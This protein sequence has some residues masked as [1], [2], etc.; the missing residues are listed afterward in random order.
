TS[1]GG[2]VPTSNTVTYLYDKSAPTVAATVTAISA[3]TGTA[4]DYIT[5][6]ASQTVRGTFTGT[7]GSCETIQA[8]ANGSTWVPA[9]VSGS[10]WSA[11][12][13][14]LSAGATLLSSRTT[15]TASTTTTA[16]GHSYPHDTT[17]PT[18]AATVTAISA[19]TGTA[20]DYITSTA[21]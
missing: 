19:D 11:S 8:S 5:S 7:L 14:T 12:G 6:T 13:V 15:A 20:G 1:F 2:S 4:G 21:A 18:A 16:T 9:T 17:A 3:D 10:T